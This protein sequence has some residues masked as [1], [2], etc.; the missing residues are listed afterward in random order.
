MDKNARVEK[1]KT[2]SLVSGQTSRKIV[3]GEAL[4]Q[5]ERRPVTEKD[6]AATAKVASF[7]RNLL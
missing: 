1:G 4:T 7:G 3:D 5:R 2:P 6:V